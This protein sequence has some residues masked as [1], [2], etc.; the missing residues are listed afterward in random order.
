MKNLWLFGFMLTATA[1]FA[2]VDVGEKMPLETCKK[3]MENQKSSYSDREDAYVSLLKSGEKGF[4][5]VSN[6]F[7][8]G[9]VSIAEWTN[10]SFDYQ[11]RFEDGP[12]HERS[13][14]TFLFARLDK[15]E[16]FAKKFSLWW[17]GGKYD[18]GSCL[19]LLG[20]K[21]AGMRRVGYIIL[22]NRYPN[23]PVFD[24]Q[25]GDE[26]R[27]KQLQDIETFLKSNKTGQ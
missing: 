6:S 25:A 2:Q 3:T 5:I 14:E 20:D 11:S 18:A 22:Q 23:T 13:F 15:D 4:E 1:A 10:W 19:K 8:N 26:V 7:L 21:N 12:S 9:T 16:G 17:S 27:T 24:Y